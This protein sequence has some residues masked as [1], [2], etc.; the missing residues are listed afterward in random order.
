MVSLHFLFYYL[1]IKQNRQG[2]L[3]SASFE[4]FNSS[5]LYTEQYIIIY[6]IENL[7]IL[8]NLV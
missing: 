3:Q 5:R 6:S 7:I 2:I 4:L 8:N 1:C